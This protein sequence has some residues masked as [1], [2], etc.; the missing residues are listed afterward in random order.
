MTA[1]FRSWDGPD[2]V[3][4]AALDER[5]RCV[6]RWP[7][8][9]YEQMRIWAYTHRHRGLKY[10]YVSTETYAEAIPDIQR[11]VRGTDPHRV[12]GPLPNP[13]H[14]EPDTILTTTL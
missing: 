10:A 11:R 3:A 4:I 9:E 1:V 6:A 14:E 2:I 7:V 12:Y 13:P 5:G 8:S